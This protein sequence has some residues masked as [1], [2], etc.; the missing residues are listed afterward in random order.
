MTIPLSVAGLLAI[1]AVSMVLTGGMVRKNPRLLGLLKGPEILKREEAEFVAK[2]GRSISLP[3]DEKP[4]VASVKDLNK[5]SGQAFFKDAREDDKV[6]IYT[7][8]KKVVLYRPSEA[9]VVE[10]GSINI[11][12]DKGVVAGEQTSV[13]V[14]PFKVALLN[15]TST[16]ELTSRLEDELKKLLPEGEV[17]FRAN[18]EKSDYEKSVVVN[19]N[20]DR[21]SEAEL[22]AK[23][24]GLEVGQLPDGET[25]PESGD[26]LVIIGK[27]RI[28]SK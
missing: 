9:R 24:L 27:D 3:T 11:S 7:N 17:V 4:T 5:L 26:V 21:K 25:K 8:A 15:G 1:I 13:N 20:E 23:K 6:L 19:L 22:L 14:T 18:A 16:T 12:S 28:Y 2:V 10:V